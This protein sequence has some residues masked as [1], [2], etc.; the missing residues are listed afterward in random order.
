MAEAL[1][2]FLMSLLALAL[3]FLAQGIPEVLR[4][5]PSGRWY[6]VVLVVM[7]VSG[8]SMGACALKGAYDISL[9]LMP[10]F[11]LMEF[12]GNRTLRDTEIF[13]DRVLNETN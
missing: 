2:W 8:F 6:P 10:V 12:V 4:Y 3:Y 11:L 7:A 9:G 1:A 5:H 13:R